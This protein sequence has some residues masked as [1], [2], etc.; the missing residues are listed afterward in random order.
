V[1]PTLERYQ[2]IAPLY[3]ILDA[4]F[5]IVRHRRLRP[6]V[7]AGLSGRLLDAGIGTG[8]NIPFYP[9]GAEVVGIDASPAMLARAVRRRRVAAGWMAFA[10]MDI[11]RLA[12][13]DDCFDAAVA[14]FLFCVLPGDLQEKALRELAR[15]VRPGGRIVLLD[16]VMPRSTVRRLVA[17]VWEPWMRWAFGAGSDR[18]TEDCLEAAGLA[19]VDSR[20]VVGERIRLM[21]LAVRASRARGP[22]GGSVARLV[23]ESRGSGPEGRA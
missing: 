11:T 1:T 16:Y 5:E 22:D 18:R 20:L 2:R 7:F 21:G 17:R 12:F 8:R 4:P 9:L 19:V 15:V 14:T 6:L 23:R 10:R 13:A 3:D